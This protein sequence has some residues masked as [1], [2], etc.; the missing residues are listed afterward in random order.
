MLTYA[1]VRWLADHL[2]QPETRSAAAA[3]AGTAAAG[4][5]AKRNGAVGVSGGGDKGGKD[6]RPEVR[7][8]VYIYIYT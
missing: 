6:S 2:D 7:L 3:A 5:P 8:S 1:D 4:E